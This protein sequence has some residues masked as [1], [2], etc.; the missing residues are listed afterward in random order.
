M[1]RGK[2]TGGRKKG[3][4]NKV[5]SEAK[6]VAIAFLNRRTEAELDELWE[7]AKAESA[8]KALTTYMGALEFVLPKLGRTEHV[9][10]GG[11]PVEYVIRD[12]AKEGT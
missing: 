7:A 11:G 3:T 9:G 2:K 6:V 4:P 5:T 10:D 12:L 8:S 1:A